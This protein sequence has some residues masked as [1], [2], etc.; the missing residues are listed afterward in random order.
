LYSPKYSLDKRNKIAP[1]WNTEETLCISGAGDGDNTTMH[2]NSRIMPAGY[3]VEGP[4]AGGGCDDGGL[5]TA[6]NY[7]GRPLTN[8]FSGNHGEDAE[9]CF[10][11]LRENTTATTS[12]KLNII[13]G[14][15][16]NGG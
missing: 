9:L 1:Y 15:G 13:S 10:D 7:M 11:N 2:Y 4:D 8:I 3:V 5:F 16:E 6:S 12:D 14:S